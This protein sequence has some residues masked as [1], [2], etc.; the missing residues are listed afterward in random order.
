MGRIDNVGFY[1]WTTDGVVARQRL[2]AEG[3]S[4]RARV[5]GI[6]VYGDTVRVAWAVQGHT[7]WAEPTASGDLLDH[8]RVVER[9]V[10]ATK[11]VPF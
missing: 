5:K 2:A 1:A 8:P 11:V 6:A 7:V 9:T 10:E 4:L 3:Y